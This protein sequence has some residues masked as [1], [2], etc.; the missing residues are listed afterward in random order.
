MKIYLI[1]TTEKNIKCNKKIKKLTKKRKKQLTKTRESNIIAKHL[2]RGGL[3]QEEES[4][5]ENIFGKKIKK[6]VD[7]KREVW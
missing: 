3:L 2:E 4:G 1:P 7:K 5:A 6:A